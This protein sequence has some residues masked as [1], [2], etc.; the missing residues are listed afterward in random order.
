[1]CGALLAGAHFFGAAMKDNDHKSALPGR[2]EKIHK[3]INQIENRMESEAGKATAAD[4][5][6]LAMFERELEE[7]DD[8]DTKMSVSWVD[9]ADECE[10]DS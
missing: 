4:Y 9:R 3:M 8:L 7:E 5:L 6:R 10:S 1:M 2:R